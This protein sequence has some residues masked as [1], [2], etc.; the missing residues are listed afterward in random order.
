MKKT[1]VTP[2]VEELVLTETANGLAKEDKFDG[3]WVSINGKWYMPGSNGIS[4]VE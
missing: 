4:N 3:D 2:E 1:W